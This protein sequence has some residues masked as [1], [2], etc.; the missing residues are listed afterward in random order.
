[1]EVMKRAAGA[2]ERGGSRS[3]KQ[4]GC[5]FP[6][7]GHAPRLVPSNH[8][9]FTGVE[10]VQTQVSVKHVMTGLQSENAPCCLQPELAPCRRMKQ[11]KKKKR[12]KLFKD[13]MNKGRLK[14]R[15]VV[16][17]MGSHMSEGRSL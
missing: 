11:K 16:A 17:P 5:L 10:V 8:R 12:R 6:V 9:I 3:P 14:A 1:M 7:S 4:E 13:D 15:M 2:H